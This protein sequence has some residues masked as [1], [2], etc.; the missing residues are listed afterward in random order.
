MRNNT[1]HG[2]F[3]MA[4]AYWYTGA[5]KYAERA[6][7][8]LYSM[9][10]NPAT[11]MNPNLEFSQVRRPFPRKSANCSRHRHCFDF[12]LIDFHQ[13]FPMLV[14]FFHWVP[15][16]FVVQGIPNTIDGRPTGIIE[17]VDFP[18]YVIEPSRLLVAGMLLVSSWKLCRSIQTV[19][20]HWFSATCYS[21]LFTTAVVRAANTRYWKMEDHQRIMD[22]A[23]E[24]VCFVQQTLLPPAAGHCGPAKDLS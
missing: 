24:F 7:E 21:M 12:D 3:S 1:Q 23:R 18:R 2:V 19:I 9:Y 6:S 13:G 16:D 15:P 8:I 4:M 11:R 17:F 5:E 14:A 22:W 10:I 20:G